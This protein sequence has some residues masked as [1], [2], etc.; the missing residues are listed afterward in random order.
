MATKPLK[1]DKM[2]HSASGA[3]V[4]V[5]ACFVHKLR[6]PPMILYT[7]SSPYDNKQFAL[8]VW[9]C[10]FK[11]WF[12]IPKLH[13]CHIGGNILLIASY[14]RFRGCGFDSQSQGLCVGLSWGEWHA[15]YYRAFVT[16]QLFTNM[17]LFF[18]FWELK[19]RGYCEAWD[20]LLWNSLESQRQ[21]AKS[22]VPRVQPEAFEQDV[23]RRFSTKRSKKLKAIQAAIV[24]EFPISH[25]RVRAWPFWQLKLHVR[26][27]T[28]ADAKGRPKVS[29]LNCFI[30]GCSQIHWSRCCL[31]ALTG[32]MQI[33]ANF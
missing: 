4:C 3:K 32:Y 18:V 2:L 17:E 14:W 5:C 16:K 19:G 27:V 22:I 7:N 9:N 15:R 1:Y 8:K 23:F 30:L 24:E 25:F 33:W 21:I 12:K 20:S 28:L 10:D 26:A 31:K 6:C 13:L 29:A 11:T